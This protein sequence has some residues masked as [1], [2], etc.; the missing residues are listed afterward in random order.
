MKKLDSLLFKAGAGETEKLMCG[1]LNDHMK[2]GEAYRLDCIFAKGR[3][4][5]SL[6]FRQTTEHFEAME[7]VE[8]AWW[9]ALEIYPTYPGGAHLT[10]LSYVD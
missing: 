9:R 5:A 7:E 10:V 8:R 1:I 4:D 3:K 2:T 6:K